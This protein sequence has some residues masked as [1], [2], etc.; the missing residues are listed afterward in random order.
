MKFYL[1]I[2][3][4]FFQLFSVAQSFP[5]EYW[6]SD[7]DILYQGGKIQNPFY[8]LSNI[9][10][11]DLLF[12]QEDFWEQLK[13]NYYS[14]T[15]IVAG[16]K[17]NDVFVG[18]VGVRFR[19]NTS[20]IMIPQ[21]EK[22][23]FKIDVDFVD[24]DLALEGYKNLRFN[25]SH[26]DP[27]F[28]R[29]VLYC[30]LASRYIPIAKANFIHLYINGEDWGLYPN[31]QHLDKTFLE[32]WFLSNDG[33][34]FRATVDE[35]S[36]SSNW[37]DGTSALNYLGMDTVLYQEYY[38]LKSS[39]IDSS[40][41]KLVDACYALDKV[42]ELNVENA[43]N[44]LD[45]DKILWFLAVENIFTDDDSY[46]EKGKMDYM[47][48]YE[49][50][51]GRLSSIEYDGNSTFQS[52]D[53]TNTTWGPF[54]NV[55]NVNYPLLSKL[56][57]IP[58]YRQRYL[59][60]YRTILN[61]VFHP[62]VIDSLIDELDAQIA[63][64]VENDPKKLY[65]YD[66]YRESI[67]E[68]KDFADNRRNYLFSYLE[69]LENAPDIQ[70]VQFF[71]NNMEEGVS[72]YKQE[73]VH[74]QATISDDVTVREANL[75]YSSDIVGKFEKI[76]MFDDGMHNDGSAKDHTFGAEIPEMEEGTWVRF[77]IEAVANTKS[78]S[79]SYSPAGAEH[80]VFVYQV[81]STLS[82]NGVVINE[83]MAD[84]GSTAT[85]EEGKYEDWVELF[86]TNDFEMDL[87]GYYLSDDADE[88]QKWQFPESTVIEPNAYLI[89]WTDDNEKDG[90][91]HASF[92][93]SADGEELILSDPELNIA[94]R[95]SFAEQTEDISY[96]RYPNGTGDF[97]LQAPTF[98]KSNDNLVAVSEYPEQLDELIVYPV[99]VRDI[100][101]VSIKGESRGSEI[102]IL[103]SFGQTVKIVDSS[104]KM[105]NVQSWAEGIYF[106]VYNNHVTKFIKSY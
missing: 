66:A 61:E 33:A 74:V 55:N 52:E 18:N 90:P 58:A 57:N 28:M 32:E 72:P 70:S 71:N 93:L 25:N 35:V 47:A 19:G 8:H 69:V 101:N 50:E 63:D 22:K 43:E 29:E 7:N 45:I 60:H 34:F 65:S 38:T 76:S 42:G 14:E 13:E 26:L 103:N 53:A 75:Y 17:Y 1:I 100:L 77:Y 37:G 46:V 48:Y 99:P 64:L 86:N 89:V 16:L 44:Y 24:E 6:I 79:V 88:L 102:I 97:R 11:I 27:S 67:S 20:Y 96:A 56:L 78:K 23:S 98:N 40:W 104:T 68:L 106:L 81:K 21:S 85:D 39:D 2:L 15:P 91:M 73:S 41:S 80:D 4:F 36:G 12:E 9:A 62:G 30:K 92:K 31:V 94:D 51:T 54:K 83:L 3:L 95:V 5:Q 84:N 87:G 82:E 105:I 10:K 59:A 49:P